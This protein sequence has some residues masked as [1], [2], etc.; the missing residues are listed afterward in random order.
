MNTVRKLLIV[1]RV[2]H[3]RHEGQFHTYAPY[4]REINIWADLFKEV[5]IVG[6]LRDEPPAGD[7][8]PLAANVMVLPVAELSGAG[9]GGRL[10]QAA[11]LPATIW[12]LMRSMCQADAIHVR[13]PCDLGLLGVLL[14]PLFSRRL[15]AKYATQWTGFAG[16]PLAWRLQRALLRS[17]WWRG[18][19]TVYGD[20]PDQPAHVV[21]FFTSVLT[22]EQVGRAHAVMTARTCSPDQPLRVLFVGR[23]SKSKNVD[24]VLEA[25]AMARRLGEQVSCLIVGEGPERTALEARA[26]QLGLNGYARFAGGVS[27]ERVLEFYEQSDA[28]VLVSELEGWPKAIAEGMSFGLTCIG[29]DRGMVP[30]MLGDGRGIVVSPGDVGA[31]SVALQKVAAHRD[32]GREMGCRAAAWAQQHSLEGLREALR[33]LLAER[34]QLKESQAD[35]AGERTAT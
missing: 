20:W 34:W 17:W 22:E 23:L 14:A 27:F 1:A 15:Y 33:Q 28:L 21:S 3:Y 11:R 24:V 29:A 25:V 8:T 10:R 7:C 12:K 31:L 6:T 9:F 2:D 35:G 18:P 32:L 5:T 16:E 13:C 26:R 19:V 4:G 30:Q